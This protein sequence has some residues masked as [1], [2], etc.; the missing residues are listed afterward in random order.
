MP[1]KGHEGREDLIGEHRWGD[2]GQMILLVLFLVVWI[3]DSFIFKF[4]TFLSSTI[5]V[6][7]RIPVG[8]MILILSGILAKKNLDI[9]FGEVREKPEVIRKGA[10]KRMRHPVYVSSILLY[11]PFILFTMSILSFTLW[12]FIILFYFIIS[13]YEEKLLVKHFGD[14]YIAYMKEVPMWIPVR[15]K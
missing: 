4:S 5:P 10:F 8:I 6:T 11:V 13:R 1:R 14:D 9:V 2:A 12:I 7:I 3:A 15:L